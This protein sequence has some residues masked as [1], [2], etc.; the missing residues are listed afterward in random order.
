MN[1]KATIGLSEAHHTAYFSAQED[2]NER[3]EDTLAAYRAVTGLISGQILG[4]NLEHIKSDDLN[5]LLRLIGHEFE[6]VLNSRKEGV[7]WKTN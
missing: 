3:F 5:S 2:P 7:S 4:S 6:Q 1:M